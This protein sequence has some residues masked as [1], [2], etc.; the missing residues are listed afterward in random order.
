VDSQDEVLDVL[1]QPKRDK[2]A[3]VKLTR[4]LLK[5]QGYAPQVLVTDKRRSYADGKRYLE[6]GAMHE[7][8]LRANNPAENSHQPV[9]R[10]EGKMQGF[11]S[12]GSA[13]RCLSCHSA[14][15]NTFNLQRHLISRRTL[16]LFRAVAASAWRFRPRQPEMNPLRLQVRAS[17]LNVIMLHKPSGMR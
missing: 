1:V 8:D 17:E 10:R 12:P 6:L 9:R 5:K 7:H 4:K 14:A 3:A 16:R 2:A 11:K 15:Y 13:P